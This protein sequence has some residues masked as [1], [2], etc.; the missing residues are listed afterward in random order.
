MSAESEFSERFSYLVRNVP[1]FPKPGIMF[2]DI[3]PL[4]YSP[5]ARKAVILTLTEQFRQSSI[6]AVAGIE[7][8][9][10]L[11]GVPLADA[12]GVP[13]IPVRKAGKLP[14]VRVSETYE[15]EY[16]QATIEMHTDAVQKGQRILLHDDLLATGG[17]CLAA[18]RLIK[19]LDGV[20]AA[21]SFLINLSFLD[22][23]DKIKSE[24]GAEPKWLIK[25]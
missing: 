18:A 4:L 13:F 8:R 23:A 20:P 1:D 3:T 2:K 22:G 19:K 16:G 25:Y 12:L 7:A 10:F 9:G 6:D 17:T 21:F 15:L 11:F 24:F 14:S 5:D